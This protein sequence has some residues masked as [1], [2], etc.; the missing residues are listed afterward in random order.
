MVDAVTVLQGIQERDKW[1]RRAELLAESLAQVQERRRR[2]QA[3]LRRL[4]RDISKLRK[5]ASSMPDIAHTPSREVR[6][7]PL[8]PIL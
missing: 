5:V 2:T 6:V 3:R 8:G 7:A 1:R 4:D